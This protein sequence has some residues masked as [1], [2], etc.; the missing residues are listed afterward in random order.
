MTTALAQNSSP[1][2]PVVEPTVQVNRYLI[3]GQL[4]LPDSEIS[5]TLA[6][7]HGPGKTIRDIEAASKA[8]EDAVK[9]KGFSFYRIFVPAQKPQGGVI[10]LKVI[11]YQIN[12]VEVSGNEHFNADNIRRG[13]PA[14]TEGSSP[15]MRVIAEQLSTTNNNPSKQV[16]INFRESAN[17]H[18]L[19]AVVRVRD[20]DPESYVISYAGN[21]SLSGAGINGRDNINRVSGVYQHSN[22]LDLDQVLTLS[23]TT[24]I[25]NLGGVKLFGAYYQAPMYGA[26]L[27]LSGFL[28]YSELNSGTVQQGSGTFDVNGGGRFFG[29]RISQSLNRW[30]LVQHSISLGVEQRHFDNSTSFNNVQVYPDV[31]SRTLNPQYNFRIDHDTGIFAGNLGFMRN[32]RGG[33]SNNNDSHTQNGGSRAWSAWRFSVEGLWR[34]EQWQLTARLKGQYSGKPLISGEQ[35]GLGGAN[36]VRGFADRAIAG[37]WGYQWGFEAVGPTFENVAVRPV[38]FTEGGWAKSN[39]TGASDTIMGAGTGI[40]YLNGNFQ[41]SADI[42]TVL[43]K[44]S[45]ETRAHPWRLSVSAS[46]KF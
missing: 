30:G 28:T 5:A 40:R 1:S 39:L 35:F 21:A 24:D 29:G 32:I 14:L 11:E 20:S 31:S 6:P 34:K 8:L 23:Y 41:L 17:T 25:E 33:D 26:G 36:S 10:V 38:L 4:P 13:I 45:Y 7:Y 44:P 15:N 27:T 22:V 9:N 42:A 37:D 43:D 16:S 2:S 46:H 18:S 3:E 19:D 12:Q